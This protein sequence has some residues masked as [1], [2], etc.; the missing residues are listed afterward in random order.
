MARWDEVQAWARGAFQLD[1][2]EAHEFA[3][4]VTRQQGERTRAQRVMVRHFEAW[5]E[6][7]IELRSAFGEIDD[8]DPRALLTESLHLPLGG[9]A[10]HGRFLV[11]VHR[12]RLA[13]LT[14]DSVQ[15]LLSRVSLVADE[16]EERRGSDRF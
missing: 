7:M 15:Y 9:I 2:D 13:P 16:L 10:L 1:R 4:T 8:L 5:D 14:L 11:V 12:E 3:L 6:P